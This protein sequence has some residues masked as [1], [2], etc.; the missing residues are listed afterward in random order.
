MKRFYQMKRLF[1]M[2]RLTFFTCLLS[3]GLPGVALAGTAAATACADKLS[4]AAQKIYRA[5]RANSDP[6]SS[7]RDRVRT[8][9]RAL[10]IAG[11]LERSQ[12]K[13]SAEAAGACLKLEGP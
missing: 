5:V 12:A 7:L 4:P 1:Q 11:S 8:Q 13:P 10:V 6:S 3:V 2:K 9:T